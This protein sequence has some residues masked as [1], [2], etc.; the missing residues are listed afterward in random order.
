MN[1]KIKD[2][3]IFNIGSDED[4]ILR[5]LNYIPYEFDG[6]KRVLFLVDK[7]GLKMLKKLK[8]HIRG[9]INAI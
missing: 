7:F 9:N 2:M 8:K 4:L 1:S 5:T 6:G 3:V